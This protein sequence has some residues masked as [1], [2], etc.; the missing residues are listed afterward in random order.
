[1]HE[2]LTLATYTIQGSTMTWSGIVKGVPFTV[3]FTRVG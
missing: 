2:V 1:M 3:T